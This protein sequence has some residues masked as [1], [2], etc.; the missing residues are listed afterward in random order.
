MREAYGALTRNQ[1]GVTGRSFRRHQ[2]LLSAR[3]LLVPAGSD[4]IVGVF[5]LFRARQRLTAGETAIGR[6]S[7]NPSARL[8]S[9]LHHN[10]AE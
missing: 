10:K 7:G 8:S 2:L 5:L 3:D 6:Q 4:P 1:D 9:P